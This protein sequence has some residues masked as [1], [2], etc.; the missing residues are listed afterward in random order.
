MP[1]PGGVGRVEDGP[2]HPSAPHP[3]LRLP[4]DGQEAGH[5]HSQ[6]AVLDQYRLKRSALLIETGR[7]DQGCIG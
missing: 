2:A 3:T 7:T 1:L 6:T 4:Q 5:R